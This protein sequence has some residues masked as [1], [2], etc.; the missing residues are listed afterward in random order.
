MK[1]FFS[2][3]LFRIANKIDIADLNFDERE[4]ILRIIFA[5]MN[6]GKKI[7]V[8]Q[9]GNQYLNGDTDNDQTNKKLTT[10]NLDLTNEKNTLRESILERSRALGIRE[11]TE[12][13]I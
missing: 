5:K 8:D 1:F 10:E 7:S 6:V 13:S 11:K 12:D 9:I 3:N 4:K 2:I